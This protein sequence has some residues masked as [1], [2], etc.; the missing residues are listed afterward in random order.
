[1]ERYSLRCK[2][3]SQLRRMGQREGSNAPTSLDSALVKAGDVLMHPHVRA[4]G[5]ALSC[6]LLCWLGFPMWVLTSKKCMTP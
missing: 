6:T 2:G 3:G 5:F 1:M 4:A